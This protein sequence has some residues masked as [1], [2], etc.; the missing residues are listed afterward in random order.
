MLYVKCYVECYILFKSYYWI[1]YIDTKQVLYEMLETIFEL[2]YW[3]VIETVI[4][5]SNHY[6]EMLQKT[7]IQ[8]VWLNCYMNCSY[9]SYQEVLYKIMI[10]LYD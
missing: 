2:Y 9:Y 7:M 4:D 5:D 10:R 1:V 6:Q 8:T 3:S